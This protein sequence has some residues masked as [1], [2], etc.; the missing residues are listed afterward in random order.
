MTHASLFTGIGGFD[1]AA[2]AVGWN[3]I[4]QVEID[5]Y[6][7]QVLE[8]NFP[9]VQRYKDIKEFDGKPYRGAIDVISGGFPCFKGDTV[10]LTSNGYKPIEEI[11]VG[12]KVYTKEGRL[13]KVNATMNRNICDSMKIK[14]QGDYEPLNTSKNH[15]IWIKKRISPCARKYKNK[16]ENP[17]WVEAKEV[18]K[19]DL[20]ASRC[21]EGSLTIRNPEFW[22]FVG[23]YL[24]DGWIL[25]GKRKSKI[26]KGHR[27]SRVTSRNHKVVV[28]CSY[29]EKE[30]LRGKI[31]DA[32]FHAVTE[33]G[34][35]TVKFIISSKELVQFLRPFGRYAHGKMIPG[36]CYE[37]TSKLKEHLFRGWLEADGYT[38][39]NGQMVVTTVS[40]S[41]VR[42]MA[43]VARDCF[44]KPVSIAK[45]HV[46]SITSIEGRLVNQRDQYQL[47]VSVNER[48]GFYEDGFIW[49]LVKKVSLGN[50]TKVYNIGVKTDETYIANGVIVHNCQPFSVAGKRKGA[51]DDR[52]LWPEMLRIIREIK[53]RY[54]VA[55]NVPGIIKMELDTALSDLENLGYTTIPVIIPACAVD[56]PHRRDRVWVVAYTN[57]NGKSSKPIREGYNPRQDCRSALT[58]TDS[59]DDDRW[60]FESGGIPQL[61]KAR[62][63]SGE[64]WITES[65]VCR[66]DN[67]IP[68][69]VD[70]T[71]ALGNA[72]V[73]QVA[74]EIFRIIDKYDKLMNM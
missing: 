68:N 42:G 66:A 56:A 39:E 19:G 14:F 30:Y 38:K 28:C 72:I 65:P 50:S 40:Q 34:R 62:V 73:P 16:F 20:I 57:S 23:R 6:C 9:D 53:P 31:A 54:I 44:R 60:R 5:N 51:E 4:F 52:Y 48:Y 26:P 59:I 71:K 29:D 37:L 45:K 10:I 3:N 24:G 33:E 7:Q 61:E 74:Y 1:L 11:K 8:K 12:E 63:Q 67:G 17:K 49:S 27:G 43:Q 41:L 21:I 2:E 69:R 70:R 18:C 15:P 58:D 22:Y 46:S 35:A 25:D 32:G 13:K 47:T 64:W 55:E 36:L